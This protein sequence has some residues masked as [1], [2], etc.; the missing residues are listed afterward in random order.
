MILRFVSENVILLSKQL[1]HLHP[2]IVTRAKESHI[3]DFSLIMVQVSVVPSKKV[4]MIFGSLMRS[5]NDKDKT[6]SIGTILE[7]F[8]FIHNLISVNYRTVKYL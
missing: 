3:L 5:R 1:T 6:L 7:V 4:N 2:L 8:Q